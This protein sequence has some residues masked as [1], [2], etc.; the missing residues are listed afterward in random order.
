MREFRAST[1]SPVDPNFEI[2]RS[3]KTFGALPSLDENRFCREVM[4]I[5][6][7]EYRKSSEAIKK[8]RREIFFE[9]RKKSS[10]L[11]KMLLVAR[12]LDDFNLGHILFSPLLFRL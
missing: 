2:S 12:F 9:Y 4:Q 10:N 3:I 6:F 5:F 11:S 1:K 7:F 8:A